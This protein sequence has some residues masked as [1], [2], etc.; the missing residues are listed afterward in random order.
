VAASE[1]GTPAEDKEGGQAFGGGES[2][3]S[4]CTRQSVHLGM[5]MVSYLCLPQ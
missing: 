2:V 4:H 1:P 5:H 3:I